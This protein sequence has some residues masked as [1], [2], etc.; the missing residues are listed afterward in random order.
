MP[1]Y[2]LGSLEEFMTKKDYGLKLAGSIA[3]DVA[4]GIAAMHG[5]GIVHQDIKG[6][7]DV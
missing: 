1:E 7:F 6:M 3:L 2:N 5:K 4:R